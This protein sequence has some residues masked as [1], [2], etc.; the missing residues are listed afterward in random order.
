MQ[1]IFTP[2]VSADDVLRDLS[3][4]HA[5][6]RFC[7]AAA[8]MGFAKVTLRHVDIHNCQVRR[9]GPFIILQHT[10]LKIM[11]KCMSGVVN[12]NGSYITQTDSH[13]RVR[14]DVVITN[15]GF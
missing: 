3:R 10:P 5:K 7:G 14:N 13:T 6:D 11:S 2:S 9:I 4:K 8:V 1:F 15:K 12:I